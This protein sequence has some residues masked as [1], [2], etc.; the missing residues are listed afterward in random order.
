MEN[1]LKIIV[2]ILLWGWQ[3]PQNIVGLV[4][5]LFIR[6]KILLKRIGSVKIYTSPKMSGGISLGSYIFLNSRYK[7]N[8]QTI[9]HEYG[10]CKQSMILGWFYLL[11]IGFPSIIHAV[12]C[13]CRGKSYYHFYTEKWADKLMHIKR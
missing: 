1:I 10:H 7:T 2:T 6:E 12:L 13:K 3:L 11:I 9:N 8:A 4:F 5:L